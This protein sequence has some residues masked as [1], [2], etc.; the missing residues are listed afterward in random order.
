MNKSVPLDALIKNRFGKNNPAE[1]FVLSERGNI[2]L[3]A[4]DMMSINH[5]G[6][7]GSINIYIRNTLYGINEEIFF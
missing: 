4:I 3:S 6:I 7:L 5:F 1:R 2:S